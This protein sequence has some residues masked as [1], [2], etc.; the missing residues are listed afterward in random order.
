ML[1]FSFRI[2]SAS[3]LMSK[4]NLSIIIAC[5]NEGPTFEQSV[6]KIISVLKKLRKSW[7]VIFVEDK[8]SDETPQKVKELISKFKNTRAIF[9]KQNMGRGRAVADGI[10]ASRGN[11]CGY[12][13]VDLEVSADYIPI[14]VREIEKGFDMVVGKRFYEA[15]LRSIMRF[16]ASKFYATFVKI[17]LN[18]P[19]EDTEA[20]YK[21]FKRRSILPIL[22]KTK[23]N[24]WFW[25][26]E[27]CIR[28]YRAGL[29]IS[30]IPVLFV[31]RNDK[32]S[33]VR[34][35]PDSFTY[36][37]KIVKFKKNAR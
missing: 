14:F 32:K 35:I 18:L 25:D 33:T 29:A 8:S 10:L 26:T 9:H 7:E 30:Q 13:D 2:V 15:S 11:I 24:G 12:L 34:L 31:R 5:Y 4:I 37:E 17:F 1:L 3:G 19:L 36:L 22:K 21:F 6:N 23:D 16:L 20:G 28:A 27:I